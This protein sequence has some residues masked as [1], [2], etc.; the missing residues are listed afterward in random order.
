MELKHS[1]KNR[2]KQSKKKS[3]R[4]STKKKSNRQST[5]KNSETSSDLMTLI[6]Q[7]KTPNINPMKTKTNHYLSTKD[8]LRAKLEQKRVQKQIS[9][10]DIQ[11]VVE[12]NLYQSIETMKDQ[13]INHFNQLKQ[14]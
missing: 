5:K 13:K 11:K 8:R 2:K 12:Q 3:N 1:Q 14:Q 10:S 6:N 9:E 4:Q 7:L